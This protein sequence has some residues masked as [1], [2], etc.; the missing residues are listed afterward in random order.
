MAKQGKRKRTTLEAPPRPPA[1]ALWLACG[2]ALLAGGWAMHLWRQLFVARAGGEVSCPFDAEGDCGDVWQSP[3]AHVIEAATGLPVAAHGVL[4]AL[5]A[6]A[7]PAAVLVARRSGRRGEVSFAGALVDCRGGRRRDARA[8]SPRSSPTGA[9]AG[10]AASPTRGPSPTQPCVSSR[11][12]GCPGGASCGAARSPPARPRSPSRS[13]VARGPR[14]PAASAAHLPAAGSAAR[15]HPQHAARRRAGAPRR[16]PLAPRGR[17]R[18]PGAARVRGGRAADPLRA[19]LPRGLADG[20]RAHHRLRRFPVQPLRR[21]PRHPHPDRGPRAG[22]ELLRRVALLPPRR[23]VQ[24]QHR[25][26]LRAT[27]SA[28][29][30][31]AP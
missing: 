18:R 25:Q 13:L 5:V 31:R 7:L 9:S 1:L 16:E 23:P 30:R 24:P 27:A 15:A 17:G 21:A 19:S 10:A 26:R 20:A 2:V 11:C 8:R 28:A 29:S 3:I 4:W 22:G 6:L 14:A 12:L